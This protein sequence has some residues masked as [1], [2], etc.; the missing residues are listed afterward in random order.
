[1]HIPA[2]LPTMNLQDFS[3][4]TPDSEY[5]RV[6]RHETGHTLGFPHE[7]MRK[8]LVARID[9]EKAY[10]YFWD[11]QR[12]DRTTVDQQVLTPLNERS[13]MGTPADQTSI[14][15]YQVPAEIT[16]DGEPILG[17][18]DINETDY[19]FAGATTALRRPPG[20]R[21]R[22]SSRPGDRSHWP[23]RSRVGAKWRR[24]PLKSP[25]SRHKKAIDQVSSCG[26]SGATGGLVVPIGPLPRPASGQ[27]ADAR[28]APLLD[29]LH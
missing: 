9:R 10:Q 5:N 16:I 17:G 1:L 19:Q 23:R 8:D 29:R 21:S 24:N 2:N 28:R 14:M 12:W 3:M 15:C 7:H 4:A 22:A 6:V 18:I 27:R 11:T 13:L 25:D 26:T 20:R